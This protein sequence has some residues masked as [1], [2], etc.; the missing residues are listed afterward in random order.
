MT[1]SASTTSLYSTLN[2]LLMNPEERIRFKRV[3]D[4]SALFQLLK[5]FKSFERRKAKN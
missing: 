2:C 4:F 3:G 5:T 1:L